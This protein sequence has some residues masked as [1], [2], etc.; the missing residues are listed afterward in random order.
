MKYPGAVKCL[1]CEK[2]LVSFYRH[3]YKTCGCP[4]N[5]MI[6]GGYDYLRYGGVDYNMI[7]VLRFIHV[8]NEENYAKSN[9]K[10][11]KSISR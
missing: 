2:I 1:R 6:D 7:Q 3:D 10:R 9:G 8:K 4:N 11:K 5:T